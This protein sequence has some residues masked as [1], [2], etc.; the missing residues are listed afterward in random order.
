MNDSRHIAV[1][2]D[3]AIKALQ[4]R[5]GGT[6]IDGTLGGGTHTRKLL[7][8]SSPDGKVL[9]LDVDPVALERGRITM[10][11][12]GERWIGVESNFRKIAEIATRE[13][14]A[15]CDGILLDLG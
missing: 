5:S 15:P 10:R 6:Y 7:E 1:M 8:A 9:S 11:P 14:F 4:P 12:Y 2:V 3:D 13:G